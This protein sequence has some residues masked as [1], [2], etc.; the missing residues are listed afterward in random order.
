VKEIKNVNGEFITVWHNETLS[1]WREWKGW[2]EVYEK[3]IQTA[4]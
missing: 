1:D 4:L 3:V 2:K